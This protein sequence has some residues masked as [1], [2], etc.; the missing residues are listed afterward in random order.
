[1]TLRPT[2]TGGLIPDHIKKRQK[3]Q[4]KSVFKRPADKVYPFYVQIRDGKFQLYIG[5]YTTEKHAMEEAD[6][7]MIVLYGGQAILNFPDKKYDTTQMADFIERRV[8][9]KSLE[10]G[11]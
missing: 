1:M 11:E 7:A 6:K 10:R 2:L 8:R 4:P 5:K 9:Q 3:T